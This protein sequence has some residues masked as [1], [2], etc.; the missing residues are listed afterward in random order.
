[1][2]G[3]NPK[4]AIDEYKTELE[5]AFGCLEGFCRINFLKGDWSV[6]STCTWALTGNADEGMILEDCGGLIFT[7]TQ[8]LTI[9][10]CD[11]SDSGGKVRLETSAYQY[12]LI[13]P[14]RS[15]HWVM[16]WQPETPHGRKYPFPHLHM[17]PRAR[18]HLITGRMLVEH[19]IHWAIEY[20]ARPHTD[21][22]P[23][24][25]ASTR[26]KHVAERSWGESPEHG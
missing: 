19:A 13:A 23:D 5:T 9:T 16:H 24:I 22:W 4:Q 6:G 10:P 26:A 11:T 25:L 20:G 18:A 1:V 14:D 7:A 17:P 8:S 2:V 12:R 21:N 3:R 15:E